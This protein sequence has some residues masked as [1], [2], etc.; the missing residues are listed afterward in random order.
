MIYYLIMLLSSFN[1]RPTEH[2]LF[3]FFVVF[4]SMSTACLSPFGN[5][6][7]SFLLS[8]SQHSI[9]QNHSIKLSWLRSDVIWLIDILV[10]WLFSPNSTQPSFGNIAMGLLW[11][12]PMGLWQIWRYGKFPPMRIEISLSVTSVGTSLSATIFVVFLLFMH[13]MTADL[14]YRRLMHFLLLLDQD[15]MLKKLEI[16]PTLILLRLMLV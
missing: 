10:L 14:N 6:S 7:E 5:T 2:L 9:S 3:S 16:L 11:F 4:P 12:P 1:K 13:A 8:V 15:G